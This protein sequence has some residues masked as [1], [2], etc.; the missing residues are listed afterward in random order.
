MTK[1]LKIIVLTLLISNIVYPQDG[2]KRDPFEDFFPVRIIE[3]RKETIVDSGVEMPDLTLPEFDIQGILWGTD[4]PQTII[5]GEIYNIGDKIYKINTGLKIE[6]I[7]LE[8][9]RIEGNKVF[10]LYGDKVY[11]KKTKKTGG[12]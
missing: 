12:K 4:K 8:V 5:G 3:E 1:I 9:L 10:F 6:N 11:E 2:E 7:N